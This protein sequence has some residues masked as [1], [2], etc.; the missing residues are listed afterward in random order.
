[1]RKRREGPRRMLEF[2]LGRGKEREGSQALV[3]GER[4]RA[5]GARRTEKAPRGATIS[6]SVCAVANKT[7]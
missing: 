1:M 2:G 6:M 4:G 5:G 3:G 7:T